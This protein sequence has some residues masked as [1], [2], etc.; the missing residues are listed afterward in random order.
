MSQILYTKEI[1]NHIRSLIWTN[2]QASLSLSTSQLGDITFYESAEEL[3]NIIPAV[4]L[5]PETTVV[6]IRTQDL[7]YTV[8]YRFRAVLVKTF[9]VADNVIEDKIDAVNA[10][11]ELMFDN[12]GLSG[13]SLAN[14]Q[15]ERSTVVNME[16]N[17]AEEGFLVLLRGNFVAAAATI[18][19]VTHT[20]AP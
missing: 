12:T 8:T 4:F 5:K 3:D 7:R 20:N 15:V 1:G 6:A 14:A 11:A 13:L 10:I 17:P 16:Y 9:D 2:L 18:E 19:V